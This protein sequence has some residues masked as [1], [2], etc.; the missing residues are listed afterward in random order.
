[1]KFDSKQPDQLSFKYLLGFPVC[2]AA[3]CC[4]LEDRAG[5]A[6]WESVELRR[7]Q[8]FSASCIHFTGLVWGSHHIEMK[9]KWAMHP[10]A[11]TLLIDDPWGSNIPK[12]WYP[13]NVTSLLGTSYPVRNGQKW[14]FMEGW[15][16]QRLEVRRL[17][18]ANPGSAM[19]KLCFPSLSVGF[20][21]HRV[22]K[23]NWIISYVPLITQV[24]HFKL[25]LPPCW[26]GCQCV[27]VWA[28][29]LK[30]VSWFVSHS[31]ALPATVR[32]T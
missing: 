32:E 31:H 25:G 21:I 22:R 11:G 23:L 14:A 17:G 7:A 20:L 27:R 12:T 2:K 24:P 13:E 8:P 9:G 3:K 18:E 6:Q 16:A 28:K 30:V 29:A 19:K 15:E 1:M 5:S 26:Q 4:P 10:S